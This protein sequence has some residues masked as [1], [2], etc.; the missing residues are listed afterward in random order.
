LEALW[1]VL[2][3]RIRGVDIAS[4]DRGHGIGLLWEGADDGAFISIGIETPTTIY[5][6]LFGFSSGRIEFVGENLSSKTPSQVL[7][8]RKIGSDK[9]IFHGFQELKPNGK[10][11]EPEKPSLSQ[12]IT[13][14]C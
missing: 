9:A 10:L 12:H 1:F 3:C 13:T 14:F 2:D 4:S 6:I 5:E 7:I 11:I 8:N